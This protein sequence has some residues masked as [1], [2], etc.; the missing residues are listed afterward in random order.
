VRHGTDIFG[1]VDLAA[2]AAAFPPRTEDYVMLVDANCA[3]GRFLILIA[4][5]LVALPAS[6]EAGE[7]GKFQG[8]AVLEVTKF[9]EVKTMEGHPMKSGMVGE[10]DGL[11]FHNGGG[12]AL[13][14]M[15]ERAHYQVVFLNDGGGKGYCMKT[16]TT[17]DGHKLFGRCEANATSNGGY[18]TVALLGGTGPF[19]GIKG[20]GKFTVVCVTDRVC[21]DDIEWEW[22]TP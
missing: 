6:A 22:E 3:A 13:D 10:M 20:K 12:A 21:W 15:L 8:H 17:K 18:G 9:T 14:R 16:F 2:V 7:K 11:M 1:R 5:V 19:N 4:T